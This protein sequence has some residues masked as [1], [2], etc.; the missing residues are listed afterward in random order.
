MKVVKEET[1]ELEYICTKKVREKNERKQG[2]NNSEMLRDIGSGQ[3]HYHL[4]TQS[5]NRKQ[6]NPGRKEE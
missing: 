1:V 3:R 4:F 6:I 5:S 2:S